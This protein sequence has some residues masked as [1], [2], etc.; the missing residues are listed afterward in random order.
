MSDL[1]M[2]KKMI[3]AGSAAC[4]ADVL[5]FPFDVAK[6]RLQVA[7]KTVG[8]NVKSGLF[9]TLVNIAKTEGL[10]SWWNGIIPG[11]QRQCVFASIRIGMYDSTKNFYC[12]LFGLDPKKN[13]SAMPIRILSGITSGAVAISFA[14][15]TDVVKVRMQ[16]SSGTVGAT[17]SSVDMYRAI[18]RQKGLLGLWVGLLP[19]MARNSIVNATELVAYDT[20]KDLLI[21]NKLLN[22]GLACHFSSGFCA[23][24]MATLVASPIDVVKT[25]VMNGAQGMSFIKCAQELAI[26][27]GFFGFYKGFTPSF[28]RMGTWNICMFVTFEQ[29]KKLS[30]EIDRNYFFDRLPIH[31]GSL[32][33]MDKRKADL[34]K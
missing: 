32:S 13:A 28:M 9:G 12:D 29:F 14:Q 8:H 33:L 16:A 20:F 18:Y 22:D 6:V 34:L 15:P 1:T 19:N 4:V 5:T 31:F 30:T 17:K 2:S 21:K 25:R 3:C 11:L 7:Q 26:R 24:F 27:E 10:K 23:G